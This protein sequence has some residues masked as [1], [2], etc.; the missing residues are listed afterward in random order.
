MCVLLNVYLMFA[1][2]NHILHLRGVS[3]KRFIEVNFEF[4][5]SLQT[6]ASFY[7]H[8]VYILVT[9]ECNYAV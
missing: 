6:R 2:Q 9:F 3:F 4:I 8:I 7:L 1:L 5:L